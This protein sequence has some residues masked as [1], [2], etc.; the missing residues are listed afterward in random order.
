MLMNAWQQGR[1][2][3]GHVEA[4]RSQSSFRDGKLANFRCLASPVLSFSASQ[5]TRTDEKLIAEPRY[6]K[7]PPFWGMKVSIFNQNVG[8]FQSG[9]SRHDFVTSLTEAT[10]CTQIIASSETFHH[11]EEHS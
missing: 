7:T 8:S 3:G 6:T 11:W 2:G 10:L 4:A 5:F 9:W 1:R